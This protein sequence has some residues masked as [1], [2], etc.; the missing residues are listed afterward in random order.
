MLQP[1]RVIDNHGERAV[2]AKP[3][4]CLN[5]LAVA[6]AAAAAWVA[7]ACAVL[8]N[9]ENL[10]RPST[11]VTACGSSTACARDV[12]EHT[13]GGDVTLSGGVILTNTSGP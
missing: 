2:T 9:F 3:R 12:T 1:R 8:V 6:A 11:F 13:A 7:P 5:I 10:S 4:R